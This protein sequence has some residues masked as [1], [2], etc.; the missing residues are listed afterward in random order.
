MIT[1]KFHPFG[2]P[3]SDWFI[4]EEVDRIFTYFIHETTEYMFE[5]SNL[6]LLQAIRARLVDFPSLIGNIK[7]LCHDG[8]AGEPYNFVEMNL[9]KYLACD[10]WPSITDMDANYSV[11]ILKY[12]V[13]ESRKDREKRQKLK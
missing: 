6:L 2:R 7:L 13:T 12:S 1:I 3:V 11:K 10:K 9:N 4:E 5:Y 8:E